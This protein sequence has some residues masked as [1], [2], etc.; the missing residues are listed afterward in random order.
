M[1]PYHRQI[2]R[3]ATALTWDSFV[4][5]ELEKGPIGIRSERIGRCR[6]LIGAVTTTLIEAK[7]AAGAANEE[8]VLSVLA[9]GGER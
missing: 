5:V 6:T 8:L 3:S 9:A 2:G 7:E 4:D 1:W